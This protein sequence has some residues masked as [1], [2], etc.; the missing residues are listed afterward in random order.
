MGRRRRKEAKIVKKTLPEFYP[1]PRCGKNT[2]KA[3]VNK[4]TGRIVVMCGNCNLRAS[5]EAPPDTMEIDAY[6][7]FVDNYYGAREREDK[8]VG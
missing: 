5:M 3:T 4:K 7:I 2:A 1:C 8:V 6:N